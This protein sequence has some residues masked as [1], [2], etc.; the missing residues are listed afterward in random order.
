MVVENQDVGLVGS[1]SLRCSRRASMDGT[2][3]EFCERTSGE[4]TGKVSL[5]MAIGDARGEKTDSQSAS[6]PVVARKGCDEREKEIRG[7]CE[8]ETAPD[9]V[10][11]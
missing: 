1:T 7:G 6:I 8:G 2:R 3:E 9:R 11:V 5:K 10:S 4:E